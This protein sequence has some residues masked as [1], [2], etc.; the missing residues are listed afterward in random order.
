MMNKF[1]KVED[2]YDALDNAIERYTS[3]SIKRP[4]FEKIIEDLN[5]N[6]FGI[7]IDKNLIKDNRSDFNEH[8][9]VSYEYDEE[10]GSYN[11]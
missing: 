2:L 3:E 8:G 6:S 10:D 11:G 9:L 4:E 1:T 5:K 7:V